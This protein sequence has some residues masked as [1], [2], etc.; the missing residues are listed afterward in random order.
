MTRI[1]VLGGTFDPIHVGHLAVAREA[2]S[3][4]ELDRLLIVPSRTP[5][6]KA[7]AAAPAEDR[8]AMCRLA[9][10]AL[11]D[12]DVSDL[13]V[14]REGPSYTAETLAELSAA[15]P[16]AE[17]HLILGWDAA[18]LLPQWREPGRVVELARLAI[19]RRPGVAGP[20]QAELQAAGI[21]PS[22]ATICEAATPDVDA[23]EVR[24]RVAAGRPLEGLVPA[25]VAEY[26]RLHALYGSPP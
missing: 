9:A 7:A 24:R 13:E 1:G 21:D 11:P 26:I 5:P 16:A 23:T 10:G 14:R 2:R 4:L 12:T 18:R 6:H 25:S 3:C 19:F 20:A 17:L 15:N 8:L 22:R